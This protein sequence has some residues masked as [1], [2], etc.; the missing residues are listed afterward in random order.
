MKYLVSL[1]FS[2]LLTVSSLSAQSTATGWLSALNAS[3]GSR[4]ALDFSVA[5][6]GEQL[7]GYYMVDG[8]GYYMSL[9]V[10]EVYSDGKLRYE[11]NNER[12]EVTEDRVNLKAQDLLTNPTRAFY[13]V[14]SE[15][16]VSIVSESASDVVLSLVP[17][18][19]ELDFSHIAL[20]LG[21]SNARVLP[22]KI[23]Y[24]YEGDTMTIVLLERATGSAKLPRWDKT[25]YGDYDIVSF[26]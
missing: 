16:E 10:M 4:Y 9:G 19:S 18:G 14:E 5:V 2:L 12:R 11:I 25:K 3:L 1:L 17:R 23:V 24:S 7:S 13:F 6:D 26:L 20:T 22:R 15:Y 8:D 21:R